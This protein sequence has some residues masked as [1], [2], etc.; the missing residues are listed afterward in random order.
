MTSLQVDEELWR[1]FKV[2]CAKLDKNL[3]EVLE[4]MLRRELGDE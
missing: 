4:A 3:Y 1:R 2:H